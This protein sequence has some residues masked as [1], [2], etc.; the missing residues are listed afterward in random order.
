MCLD[1]LLE[2]EGELSE[3]TSSRQLCQTLALDIE[4]EKKGGS[5]GLLDS[6]RIKGSGAIRFA[7]TQIRILRNE[8]GEK[9]GEK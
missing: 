9:K 2:R 8:D 6:L 1:T 4:Q 7:Y 5:R 3:L